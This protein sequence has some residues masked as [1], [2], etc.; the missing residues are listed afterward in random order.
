MSAILR[1]ETT[2]AA[3]AGG[4]A[5]CYAITI[6][7]GRSLAKAHLP[8]STTLGL[9]FSFAG[10]VLLAVLAVRRMPLLPPRGERLGVIGLGALG[11]ATESTFFYLALG[12]GTAAAVA[13]LFY[14]YP[15]IVTAFQFA[16]GERTAGRTTLIA[17]MLS[18][19]GTALIVTTGDRFSITT[20]GVLYAL[21]SA[22]TF[23]VYLVTSY[24]VVKRTDA[25]TSGAWV[26]I[27]AAVALLI[28]GAV[29]GGLVWPS[30]RWLQLALYALA[31]SAAFSLMYAGLF[32]LG[33]SR[34]SVVMTL[35]AFFAVVLGALVLGEG[36]S[37]LQLV[38]GAAV[39]AGTA[40]ISIRRTTPAEV[41]LMAWPHCP[42][43]QTRSGSCRCTNPVASPRRRGQRRS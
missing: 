39:L 18:A 13:L 12:R 26:A 4:A 9:R 5:F 17:L 40:L 11:Y 1:R 2:G 25:L 27:G 37:P 36:L 22:T 8:P 29:F 23:A 14:A 20:T 42:T 35:E 16:I 31:T 28:R 34:T 32:R 19:T 24:R 30:G 43:A 10:L 21:G 3:L 38:G 33:P 6:V 7:V 41:Y 15:A